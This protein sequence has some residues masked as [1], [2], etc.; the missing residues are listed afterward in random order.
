MNYLRKAGVALAA[1]GVLAFAMSGPAKAQ[2]ILYFADY[3]I[4]TDRMAQALSA[5]PYTVT[6]A[7]SPT[8]FASRLGAGGFDLAVFLQQNS[9]GS[10]Y[11]AAFAALDT[12]VSNGGRAIADDWTRNPA[13]IDGFGASFTGTT[14]Y[15]QL[16]VTDPT[17]AAG[18]TNPVTL[19]NP[20]WGVFSYGLSPTTGS[21]AAQ[22]GPGPIGPM[23]IAGPSAIVIGNEGRTI[24]NGF[25]AD[26]FEGLVPVDINVGTQLF[27]NEIQLAVGGGSPAAVPEPGSLAMLFGMG[28]SGLGLMIRRRACR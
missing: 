21:S 2:N 16:T 5:L 3:N 23:S 1:L 27:T 15:T 7:S 4:G 25:L 10:A 6:T 13:H 20:G 17:L 14:N 12:F 18:V 28:L 11:D 8:D 19:N 24:F 26:T 22:F 9:S